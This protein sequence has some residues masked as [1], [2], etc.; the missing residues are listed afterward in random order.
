MVKCWNCKDLITAY[1]EKSTD[2]KLFEK[3]FSKCRVK[4][5]VLGL[6]EIRE[7]KECSDFEQS[8]RWSK[9]IEPPNFSNVGGNFIVST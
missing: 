1:L 3:E 9:T 5:I 4:G 7:E 2:K 6:H 8:K